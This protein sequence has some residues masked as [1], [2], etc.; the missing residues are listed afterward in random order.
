MSVYPRNCLQIIRSLFRFFLCFAYTQLFRARSGS[1]TILG[2]SR[3]PRIQMF[4]TSSPYRLGVSR[5]ST[6]PRSY[7][8][9]PTGILNE[10]PSLQNARAPDAENHLFGSR[11]YFLNSIELC[12][13]G[14]LSPRQKG[15]QGQLE[16]QSR[17]QDYR[18]LQGLQRLAPTLQIAA[19]K[20]ELERQ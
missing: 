14:E 9:I 15:G 5:C 3:R 10:D 1:I 11:C 16:R 4:T 20:L 18:F 6:S 2:S 19:P 13:Q 12:G 7:R 17:N 8:F